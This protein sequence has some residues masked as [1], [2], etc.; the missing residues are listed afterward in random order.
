MVSIQISGM[1]KIFYKTV[2]KNIMHFPACHPDNGIKFPA[3]HPDNGIKECELCVSQTHR[4]VSNTKKVAIENKIAT[5]IE[6]SI[7]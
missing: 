5:L 3:C 2:G 7:F 1:K 4:L 6:K